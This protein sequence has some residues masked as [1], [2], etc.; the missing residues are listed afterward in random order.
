[1]QDPG[2]RG[3]PGVRIA[4]A[5]GLIATT[6]T[7]GR[8]HITC[9]V[10]PREDRGSNFIL[11]LDN[12]TLPSGYRSSSD[13][14]KVLRATRGKAVRCNFGASIHRVIGLDLA[15]AVFEPGATQMR[16]QWRPRMAL[17][18]DELKK[19]PAILRLSYLADVEDPAVVE[20]RVN[21]VKSEITQSWREL[22][23]CYELTVETEVFWR[24]GGP[25]QQADLH[26][27]ASR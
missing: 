26:T 11:K 19:A 12:R 10:T 8:Y 21:A 25:P 15:D 27:P 5:R 4:T 3:L 16:T 18:L 9:A 23:C 20:R 17:L 13:E 14:V 24:R 22:D 7:Y 6:D 2:E 1:V